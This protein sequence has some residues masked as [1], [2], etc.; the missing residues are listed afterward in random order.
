MRV[1]FLLLVLANL[2]FFAWDHYLRAPVSAEARIQQVQMTPEKIRI[3]QPPVQQPSSSTP[4]PAAESVA[5]AACLEWGV[6]IGPEAARADAA[7]AELG[8]PEAR[9]RRVAT[10]AKGYWVLIPPLNSKAEADKAAE[11]LKGLGVTD[12]SVVAEAPRRNA[13]SLGV[14]RTEEAAQN[15]LAAVRK[16]GVNDAAMELRENFFRLVVYYVR[17]PNEATVAKL[18]TLRAGMPGTEVKAVSCPAP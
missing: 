2:A 10:E 6:F 4:T 8:L 1:L 17:E 9:I 11:T 12:Y 18:A 7:V 15:L 13:I 5:G 16:K 14:F 3:V